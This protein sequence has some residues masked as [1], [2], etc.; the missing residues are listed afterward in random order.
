MCFCECKE[1]VFFFG[2]QHEV[3][4][5]IFGPLNWAEMVNVEMN[6]SQLLVDFYIINENGLGEVR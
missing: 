4:E 2:R 5:Q 3:G 6:Y 1:K